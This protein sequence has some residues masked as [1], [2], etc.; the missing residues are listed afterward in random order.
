MTRLREKAV[1]DRVVLDALLDEVLVGHLGFVA[2]DG[3]PVVLPT[4]V[5]RDGDRVLVH[6]STGSRW[7]RAVAAGA[8]VS[9]A[10]TAVDALVDQVEREFGAID[11][12]VAVAGAL[13]PGP[14]L[15]I[16]DDDWSHS[17][18]VNVDGVVLGVRRLATVMPLGGRIVCTASLA[19]L[20]GVPDDPVYA[21]TKHAVVRFVRSGAPVL[22]YVGTVADRIAA[23]GISS[24]HLSLSHDAGIAS[25]VVVC[26][27]PDGSSREGRS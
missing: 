15:S 14:A 3:R 13:R 24:I 10:V 21:A 2:D 26:E 17:F 1:T 8:P 6:G 27:C 20:T 11:A 9:L 18:A 7:M 22:E 16:T 12:L 23:L 19:G 5:A 25:A 4:A